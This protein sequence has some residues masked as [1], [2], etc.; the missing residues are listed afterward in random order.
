MNTNQLNVQQIA[1]GAVVF[2]VLAAF[3]MVIGGE[4]T[5]HPTSEATRVFVFGLIG[6]IAGS[7]GTWLAATK[8]QDARNAAMYQSLRADVAMRDAELSTLKARA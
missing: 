8:T 5:G 2:T 4:I 1:L 7:A 3:L 6:V